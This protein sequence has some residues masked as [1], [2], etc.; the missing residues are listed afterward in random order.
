[1][2]YASLMSLSNASRHD[3]IKTIDSLARRLGSPSRSSVAS[4]ATAKTP[5]KPPSS[6]HKPKSS[7]NPGVST[8]APKKSRK[9]AR[10]D[11]SPRHKTR[12][13]AKEGKSAG[14][15]HKADGERINK[16]GPLVSRRPPE[17]SNPQQEARPS[18]ATSASPESPKTPRMTG[19]VGAAGPNRISILSFSSDSTK[20]GEIPQRRWRSAMQYATTDSDGEEYNVRPTFPLKP[21]TSTAEVRERRFFGWFGRKR[22]A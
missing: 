10:D 11:H 3:A 18:R 14:R 13:A 21:Y 4:S 1:M 19:A 22:E 9:E 17:L 6:R 12:A 2:D 16:S 20:L 8:S 15:G 7:S 5:T